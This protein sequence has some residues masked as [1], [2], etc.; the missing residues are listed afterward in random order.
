MD[1][2][3]AQWLADMGDD[4]TDD[5]TDMPWRGGNVERIAR[6]NRRAIAASGGYALCEHCGEGF[7]LANGDATAHVA[8][9][10]PIRRQR[11]TGFKRNR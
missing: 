9:H 4:Y 5:T 3:T 2:M 7:A 1:A 6:R 8:T 11:G 10:E